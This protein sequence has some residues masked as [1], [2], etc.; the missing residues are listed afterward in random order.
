MLKVLSVGAFLLGFV[1][2]PAHSAV[3]IQLG[4]NLPSAAVASEN[5]NEYIPPDAA[6]PGMVAGLGKVVTAG[7]FVFENTDPQAYFEAYPGNGRLGFSTPS[8]YAGGMNGIVK[9]RLASGGEISALKFDV[10]NGDGNPDPTRW[11]WVRTYSGGNPTGYDADFIA[12]EGSTILV[13]G[14][15]IRRGSGDHLY[16][17]G[18]AAVA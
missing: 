13:S 15:W 12:P 1:L 14:G 3:T 10:G 18:C 5:F 4:G 7:G 2:S 6:D 17:L 16:E 11:I 8:L 9:I